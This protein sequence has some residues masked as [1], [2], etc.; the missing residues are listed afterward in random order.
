[1]N[2]IGY[3]RVSTDRQDYGVDAQRE[4]IEREA[5]RRGWTVHYIVDHGKSARSLRRDGVQEAL[6]LLASGEYD[7]LVIAKLDRLSRSVVDFGNILRTAT[8][9]GWSL[10]ALDLGI[11]MTTATG[12]LVAGIL[13]QVAEWEAKIIG[14]RTKAALAVAKKE[15]GIVPGPVSAVPAE[16]ADQIAAMR[17]EGLTLQAIADDLNS[18]GIAS[19]RGGRWY[20]TSV[21]RAA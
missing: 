6:S 15:R 2:V 16:V 9:Q 21:R 3:L 8:K 1:M 17:A 12:Q 11:D 10:I 18:A 5:E 7:T 20:P 13:M 14:E 19:P 4:V